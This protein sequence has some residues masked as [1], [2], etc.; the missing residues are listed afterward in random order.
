MQPAFIAMGTATVVS[1]TSVFIFERWLRHRGRLAQNTSNSQKILS[2]FA[3]FFA[4]AGMV[5]L[6]CLTC[7][8]DVDHGTAHD[9]CLFIFMYI[10]PQSTTATALTKEKCRV[11]HLRNLHLRRISTTRDSAST[12]PHPRLLL[13]DQAGIHIRRTGCGY[14]IWCSRASASL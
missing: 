2:G 12:T 1:F 13:L 8:N 14:C 9:V 7:L 11:Y 5:G 3:T 4:F 6:I 10:F